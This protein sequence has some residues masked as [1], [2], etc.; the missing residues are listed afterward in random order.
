MTN[1]ERL[2][3][4]KRARCELQRVR[5]ELNLAVVQCPHCSRKFSL[6]VGAKQL[7]DEVDTIVGKL[8][9]W[10]ESLSRHPSTSER[11]SFDA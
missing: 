4:L 9:A 1:A 5:D 8:S 10:I 7:D 2:V 3:Y 11:V 6:D